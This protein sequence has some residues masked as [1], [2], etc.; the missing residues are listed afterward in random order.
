[1]PDAYVSGGVQ[2]GEAGVGDGDRHQARAD[3][4]QRHVQRPAL[5]ARPQP[6]V[7][8]HRDDDDVPDGVREGDDELEMLVPQRRDGRPQHEQPAAQQQR[9]RHDEPVEDRAQPA[10]DRRCDQR[11]RE[12][13]DRRE[14]G[15][16]Q[17][18]GVGERRHRHRPVEH[19]LVPGPRDLP[20]GPGQHR[21]T[22]Q[23]PRTGAWDRR[24]GAPGAGPPRR[25]TPT[26][27]PARSSTGGSP[28]ACR[29]AGRARPATAWRSPAP[30][31][32]PSHGATTRSATVSCRSHR[33]GHRGLKGFRGTNSD[34]SAESLTSAGTG[35]M[36]GRWARPR[37]TPSP[38][39]EPR[40]RAPRMSP[41]RDWERIP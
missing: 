5:L 23:A 41:A 22:E 13:P 34:E 29:R 37:R 40:S 15:Q 16:A 8:H 1:M 35:P 25:R 32:G 4:R 20:G 9:R 38:I 19:R 7:E 11:Q 14:C 2:H 27:P 28:P 18:A 12:Q 6:G 24:A 10:G 36:G 33:P 39:R 3:Q 26:R 17:V 21:G 30:P 31:P